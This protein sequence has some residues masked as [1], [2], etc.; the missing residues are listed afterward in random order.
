[1]KIILLHSIGGGSGV[2]TVTAN[3]AAALQGLGHRC[4]SIDCTPDNL[5]ALHF[6]V[7]SDAVD[8]WAR[9]ASL[10]Q[11]WVECGFE[12]T[13]GE[14]VLPFG[15]LDVESLTTLRRHLAD[16]PKNISDICPLQQGV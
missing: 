4:L 11:S 14:R 12:A 15:V 7:A 3:L 10:S 8:G 5:L 2:T 6:G 9:S 16:K 1:M 13:N